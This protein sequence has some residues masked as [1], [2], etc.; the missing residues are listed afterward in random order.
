MNKA[1][2]IDGSFG[3]GGGQILRTAL[4]LSCITGNSLKLFNIRSGRKKP[5]LMPQHVTCVNAAAEICHARVSGNEKG[6]M[7]LAFSPEH[8]RAGEYTFDI[9]TAGSCSLVFQTLLPPLILSGKPSRITIKGGT[10]VPFSPTYDYISNIFMPMLG[11]TGIAVESS[12]TRYG[13]YPKGGG[14]VTFQIYPVNKIMNM[15]AIFRGALLSV[16]GCSGVSNL[17]LTIAERQMKSVIQQLHQPDID[18]R[19]ADVP[20]YGQGTFVFLKAEYENTLAGFSSLGERGKPAEAVGKEA[21][22]QLMSF[23]ECSAC[24]DPH[25]ADQIVLY[26]SLSQ[27]ESLFTTSRI[28]QHLMTNLH[29]IK[30]FLDIQY[31]IKGELDAQGSVR[32]VPGSQVNRG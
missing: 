2:E 6:S 19:V 32:L 18:V 1:V 22:E 4:S 29:I 27:E 13:F 31:E 24:L 3:E 28:T 5:G 8:V 26:L 23:Q 17:P 20:S 10:H 15:Q 25:L 30:K 12:I 7:E 9:G 14:E 16:N 21:A 11:R